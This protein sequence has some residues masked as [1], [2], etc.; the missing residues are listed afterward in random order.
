MRYKKSQQLFQRAQHT[1]PGGVSSP[2]R[3]FRSVDHVPPFI[4]RAKGARLWDCDNNEYIDYVGSWGTAILG[5]AHE[6]V[7]RSVQEAA[8]LGL[9]YGATTPNEANLAEYIIEAIPSI[10]QVRFVTSG[11]EACMT[12]VRLARGYTGR[13]KIVKFSG[14]YHGHSDM[15]LVKGGSGIATFG[16]PDSAGI[17]QNITESTISLPFNDLNC[18]QKTFKE[19]S[20]EIAAIILE[21]IAGNGGFI[22]P[23][24]GF[25]ESLQEI[26][27]KYQ[28]LL[29]FD[30][31][32]T[33]F[34]VCWGGA[35][36]L[37]QIKP[38]LTTLG[39]VIGGGLP[40][41]A[42]GGRADIMKTLAPLGPVYQAGTL[43]GNPIALASGLQT[44][45]ILKENPSC[46]AHLARLTQQLTSG[47]R[48]LA[49]T[50]EFPI[51]TDGEGGMFGFLF[52]D[53]TINRYE[54]VNQ[55]VKLDLFCHFYKRILAKG[56][57]LAPSVYEAGFMSLAHTTE[58]IDFTL[59]AIEDVLHHLH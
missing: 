12:A 33:G 30:E 25:L 36:N 15:L 50:Y 21:P 14:H 1:M 2:V 38:D 57:Y 56:I 46:Y 29:V 48:Q 3:A 53:K 28:T 39:K 23:H 35:Q 45:R 17:P 52:T 47:L 44:L 13:N 8:S 54:D 55:H 40:L 31:V 27:K 58:D 49:K 32:M 9:S 26:C 19:Y 20:H 37:Y 24:P 59:K 18:I 11:T 41:A 42:L 6:K 34:R 43:S 16:L 22:K 10:E 7:V 51:T 5:H 4:T